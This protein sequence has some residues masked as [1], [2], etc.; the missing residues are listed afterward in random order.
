[1]KLLLPL[2][3]FSFLLIVV[4]SAPPMEKD[5]STVLQALILRFSQKFSQKMENIVEQKNT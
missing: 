5:A 1:M 3:L 2:L 4:N